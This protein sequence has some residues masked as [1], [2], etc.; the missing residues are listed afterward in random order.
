MAG[1]IWLN[2]QAPSGRKSVALLDHLIRPLEERRRDP[3]AEGLGGLEV[4]RQLDAPS[5][6]LASRTSS[7][8]SWTRNAPAARC[9]SRYSGSSMVWIP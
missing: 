9:V 1:R 2:A 6:S 5:K 3:E 7:D 4:D 8:W